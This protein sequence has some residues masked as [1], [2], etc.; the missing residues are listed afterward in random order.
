MVLIGRSD[1][2]IRKIRVA[3]LV[4]RE[5]LSRA[6]RVLDGEFFGVQNLLDHLKDDFFF[7]SIRFLQDPDDFTQ[8]D[9]IDK[10]R[11]VPGNVFFQKFRRNGGL[12]RVIPHDVSDQDVGI[13]TDH[14]VSPLDSIA[15]C[16]AFSDTGLR[17]LGMRPFSCFMEEVTGTIRQFPDS[18][19]RNSNLS[20]AWIF[21]RFLTF[22]GTVS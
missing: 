3:F 19:K 21:N 18:S 13:D 16:I 8:Y 22:L 1:P 6:V 14:P 4:I 7:A 11:I 15:C 10:T 17:G 5:C 20:P 12:V 9:L 2:I